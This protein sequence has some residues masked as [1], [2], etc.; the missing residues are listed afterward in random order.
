MH[1]GGG[2]NRA[3]IR[4]SQITIS[5]LRA[6]RILQIPILQTC[7]SQIPILLIARENVFRTLMLWKFVKL[8][9]FKI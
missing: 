5:L 8:R 2:A 1:Q 4:I 3:Q 7:I 9:F 6:K